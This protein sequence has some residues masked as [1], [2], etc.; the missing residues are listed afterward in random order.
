MGWDDFVDDEDETDEEV[1]ELDEVE[2]PEEPEEPEVSEPEPESAEA[3]PVP[4][5]PPDPPVP[6][7]AMT[8]TEAAETDHVDRV[9]VWADPGRGKTHFAYTMPDPVCIIDTEN[10]ADDIAHKFSGSEK[11]DDPLIWQPSDFDEALEA[12]DEA[13][14]YLEWFLDEHDQRGTLV[15]DS[16]SI[17]WDWAQQKYIKEWYPHSDPSSVKLEAGI[18]GGESDWKQIKDYHNK[19]FRQPIVECDYHVCWTAMQTDD[20]QTKMEEGLD[21]TPQKPG[22]EKHNVYKVNSIIR[23]TEDEDGTPVGNLEKSGLVKNKYVGL[24]YPTY[25]KHR[26]LVETVEEAETE[27]WDVQDEVNALDYN[28]A[29]T[30]GKPKYRD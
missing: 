16:M 3:D 29:L 26:K 14:E 15:V 23:I 13:F 17:M 30:E 22:G 25:P 24:D 8:G 5:T 27:G 12:R 7:N 10:K 2:E 21:Y 1:T 11:G 18:G 4:D 9:M 20:I 6:E 28:V 19:Q